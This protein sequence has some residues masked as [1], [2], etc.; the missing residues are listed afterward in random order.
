MIIPYVLRDFHE[1]QSL[2]ER[3]Q[4]QLE[5]N[6]APTLKRRFLPGMEPKETTPSRVE[7]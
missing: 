5:L 3:Y 2:T 6:N 7:Q 4:Q 1:A